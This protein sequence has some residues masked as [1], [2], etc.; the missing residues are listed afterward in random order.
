MANLCVWL[1]GQSP[2]GK[3]GDNSPWPRSLFS[4]EEE[5]S[6]STSGLTLWRHPRSRHRLFRRALSLLFQRFLKRVS[7]KSIDDSNTYFDLGSL[8]IQM[9]LAAVNKLNP[10]FLNG[11]GKQTFYSCN[12]WR[13]EM[14]SVRDA[15]R[16]NGWRRIAF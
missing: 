15:P 3:A 8:G 16:R 1:R 10:L 6:A 12:I 5:W 7:F 2:A 4:S 13:T 9:S 14:S 11:F